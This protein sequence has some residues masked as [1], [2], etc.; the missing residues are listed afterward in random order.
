MY[1]VI[2]RLPNIAI[3]RCP[4]ND[5]LEKLEND[6]YLEI[7]LCYQ[8][9]NVETN[10]KTSDFFIN[11]LDKKYIKYISGIAMYDRLKIACHHAIYRIFA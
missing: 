9:G 6:F 11:R 5:N 2:G 8:V 7:K 4:N 1:T 3:Y 10:M